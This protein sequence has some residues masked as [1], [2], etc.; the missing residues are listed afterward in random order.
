MFR[1]LKCIGWMLRE[2]LKGLKF[3]KWKPR[4]PKL[5]DHKQKFRKPKSRG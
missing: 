1:E 5:R 4:Q 3:I 2:K